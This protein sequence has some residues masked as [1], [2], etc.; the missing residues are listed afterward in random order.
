MYKFGI[1]NNHKSVY[2]AQNLVHRDAGA[3]G[4]GWFG[5]ESRGR[6]ALVLAL[7]DCITCPEEQF[8]GLALSLCK[9]YDKAN[10]SFQII[11]FIFMDVCVCVYSVFDSEHF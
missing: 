11:C 2:K 6:L 5:V 10:M 3:R 8:A 1:N 7:C 4:W 9:S